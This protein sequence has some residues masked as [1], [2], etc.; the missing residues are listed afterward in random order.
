MD[1]N[2]IF[3]PENLTAEKES[4]RRMVYLLDFLPPESLIMLSYDYKIA[5]LEKLM[6]SSITGDD[7][8]RV[9]AIVYSIGASSTLKEREDFLNF[10][11]K[12]NDGVTTNFDVLFHKLDDKTLAYIL[13]T[14]SMFFKPEE[15][16]KGNFCLAV[17]KIW[18]YSTY[19]MYY[20]PEN[21]TPNSDGLNP[22]SF[23]IKDDNYK[24]YYNE[25]VDHVLKIDS[26]K[27]SSTADGPL[28]L[29]KNEWLSYT[30]DEKLEDVYINIIKTTNFDHYYLTESGNQMGNTKNDGKEISKYKLHLYQPITL[31]GFK[32]NL[33]FEIQS[34]EEGNLPAFLFYYYKE[35]DRL[36]KVYATYSLV[37][38]L[39]IE[40]ALFFGTGGLGQLKH[41]KYVTKIGNALRKAD[42]AEK[43]VVFAWKGA[44][45]VVETVTLSASTCASFSI[46]Y[47]DKANTAEEREAAEKVGL[48]FVLI[49]VSGGILSVVTR[50]K[51]LQAAKRAQ[52]S[53]G[54]HKL[55]LDTRK[56][57]DGIVG[58]EKNAAVVFL[59]RIDNKPKMKAKLNQWL[60]N[61]EA[62]HDAFITDFR[63]VDDSILTKLDQ[64]EF[65]DNYKRLFDRTIKEKSGVD[66][67]TNTNRVN[68]IT[69][70]YDVPELRAILEP[71]DS[72][73]RWIFLDEI[74]NDVNLFNRL[75]NNTDLINDW[76]KYYL[77]GNTRA[78][79]LKGNTSKQLDFL[80]DFQQINN[81]WY[82]RIRRD[83][84]LFDRYYNASSN[85]KFLAKQNPK[86]WI[87][88]NRYYPSPTGLGEKLTSSYLKANYGSYAE[89]L[90]NKVETEAQELLKLSRKQRDLNHELVSGIID[91]ETG[92]MSKLFTNFSKKQFKVESQYIAYRDTLH[93]N[94]KNLII[95]L[96]NVKSLYN[97]EN[98][99][100]L[101][102]AGHYIGAHAEV[103]ALDDL[104]KK[105]F[106]NGLIDETIF[107][108]WLEN[109]I[110]GYNRNVVVK[111]NDTKVI[112][113]R[114]CDCF[115]ITDLL[116]FIQ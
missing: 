71:L 83:P 55:P 68:A 32:Q 73:I 81:Y 95:E 25:N 20:I 88:I 57:I 62:L 56:F 116:T 76:Q 21:V 67:I 89:V 109:S 39:A 46:Y 79:F 16:S 51:T 64:D 26:V 61:D 7:E 35:F 36:R 1:E 91:K 28:T 108:E 17:Y 13:P 107:N 112:M 42:E 15:S 43:T 48:V 70:H 2:N 11:L 34:P 60:A 27:T 19:N 53:K 12:K 69:R 74:G 44:N 24:K 86:L 41:L 85:S 14:A 104:I 78:S 102:R 97:V 105:R 63:N 65:L 110:L 84:K 90:V 9:L 5:Y 22:D 103:R 115:Y 37:I 38:D 18:Y 30:A 100:N 33:D 8:S 98:L 75:E 111:P 6:K 31:S 87:K 40:V 54:Y 3:P 93:P 114:C 101:D 94:I 113:P 96:E 80:E 50:A 77:D 99:L 29:V 58:V 82:N 49:T 4:E 72:K 52:A 92:L 10:L 106:G 45:A 66:I 23:F 59:Q 47:R